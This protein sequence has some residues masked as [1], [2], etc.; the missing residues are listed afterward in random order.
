MTLAPDGSLRYEPISVGDR[1]TVVAE[2]VPEVSGETAYQ[3]EAELEPAFVELLRHLQERLADREAEHPPQPAEALP[4][5]VVFGYTA[6]E[7]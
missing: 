5:A 1:C 7:R 4:R 6:D 2:F 3:S